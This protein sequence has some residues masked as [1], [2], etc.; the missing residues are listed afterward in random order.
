[1][2][3]AIVRFGKSRTKIFSSLL[4]FRACGRE[5]VIQMEKQGVLGTFEFSKS[6]FCFAQT[7]I[8]EQN[9]SGAH[10]NAHAIDRTSHSPRDPA[11]AILESRDGQQCFGGHVKVAM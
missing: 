8:R 1:M 4:M 6:G 10:A 11:I 2:N 3:C 7:L 5:G 9:E